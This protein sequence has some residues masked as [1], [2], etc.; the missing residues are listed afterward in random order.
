LGF[1]EDHHRRSFAQSEFRSCYEVSEEAQKLRPD[2]IF[3]LPCD[4]GQ[5]NASVGD[6]LDGASFTGGGLDTDA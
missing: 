4:R 5:S 6:S 3:D 2:Y 1:H